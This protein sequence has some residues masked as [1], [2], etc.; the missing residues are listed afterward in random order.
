MRIEENYSQ[1]YII[2]DNNENSIN[3]LRNELM[4]EKV[5]NLIEN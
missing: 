4:R 3:K 2:Y 5:E 1:S